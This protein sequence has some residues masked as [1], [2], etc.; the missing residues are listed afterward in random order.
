MTDF[1]P[2]QQAVISKVEKLLRLANKN[3]NEAE[4][5]AATAKAQELLS[6]YNLDMAMVGEVSEGTSVK[7][8]QLVLKGGAYKY[9]RYLWEAVAELNFCMYWSDNK[10]I[11]YP[12]KRKY[13]DGTPYI[14]NWQRLQWH[15]FMVG[16]TVNVTATKIM[17]SYLEMTIERLLRERLKDKVSGIVPVTMLFSNWA[18]S[19]RTGAVN[20]VVEKIQER[21]DAIL[22]E[23]HKKRAAADK[24]KG[25]TSGAVA[26]SVYIDA[27]TDANNDFIH[28]AGWSAEQAALRAAAAAERRA[29]RERYTKWAAENPEEARKLEAEQRKKMEARER[30]RGSGRMRIQRDNIDYGAYNS[31]YSAAESVSIDQQVDNPTSTRR[32][33]R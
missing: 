4:A 7:R 23:E 33:G 32:I 12:V 18:V 25:S 14:Y 24:A 27:E 8:E 21:R 26:L 5:A 16:R 1:T 19:Y 20:R 11:T 31:G 29:R 2:D 15:H 28:G 9:Q 6:A 3:P 22:A 30:R 10:Y 13:S 17:A